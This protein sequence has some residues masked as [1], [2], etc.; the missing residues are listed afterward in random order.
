MTTDHSD[1][2]EDMSERERESQPAENVDFEAEP[3]HQVEVEVVAD[4]EVGIEPKPARDRA[5]LVKQLEREGDIAAD[6]LE[7][8]LDIADLDGDLDMDVEADRA[9]VS[10]VGSGLDALVGEAGAVLE[11]LQ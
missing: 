6:Y 2:T 10:I 4:V 1:R 3:D 8:L 9:A 5:D 11:A 7:E